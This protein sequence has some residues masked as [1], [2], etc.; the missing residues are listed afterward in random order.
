MTL[1]GEHSIRFFDGNYTQLNV[2]TNGTINFGGASTDY[3][4]SLSEHLSRAQIAVLWDDLNPSGGTN[5]RIRK[6]ETDDRL[7]VTFE[8]LSEYSLT[9]SNTFQAELFYD[10]RIRLSYL[11]IDLS[12]GLVG[13]SPGGVT[14]DSN[15]HVEEDFSALE[16]FWIPTIS[17]DAPDAR[18]NHSAVW[19]GT[20]MII[21]G[22][23]GFVNRG[24]AFPEL[25]TGARYNP[26][27]DRWTPTSL[28]NAA[29]ARGGHTAVW[30]G[31]EMVV[32]GGSN[33]D[34]SMIEGGGRYN[35]VQDA[36][37]PVGTNGEP[38]VR[39]L[40][41]AVWSGEEMIVWGGVDANANPMLTGARFVPASNSW[42]PVT[43]VNA[44]AARCEHSA[45]WTGTK[46]IVWG[47]ND[48]ASQVF[49]SGG[50]FDPG[51]NTWTSTS[52]AG[53]PQDI[54]RGQSAV[55][56]GTEMIV[57][58]GGQS[59]FNPI[60]TGARYNPSTDTW[61]PMSSAGA[62]DA[63]Y[64]HTAVWTGSEM[65]VWGGFGE[66]QNGL[67]SGGRYDPVSD[68]WAPLED[69]GSPDAGYLP[70]GVWAD[71]MFVV[72]GRQRDLDSERQKGGR[73]LPAATTTVAVFSGAERVS[74]GIGTLELTV[75]LGGVLPEEDYTVDFA[76]LEGTATEG[77]DYE[78]ASG[79]LLIPHGQVEGTIL[80]NILDDPTSE[81]FETFSVIL[82][83]PSEGF[84]SSRE[85]TIESSDMEAI[86]SESFEGGSLPQ[87]GWDYG[88]QGTVENA[89]GALRFG[90]QGTAYA[91]VQIDLSR[92]ST[93]VLRFRQRDAPG[94]ETL[95]QLYAGSFTSG[96]G[97]LFSADGV[98]WH[99]LIPYSVN[100]GGVWEEF[101]V[102]LTSAITEAGVD[103]TSQFRLRFQ[104][105]SST[106]SS[107]PDGGIEVD[108]IE[109]LF[110]EAP[111]LQIESI[112]VSET[113][114]T[115]PF[116]VTLSRPS[117][118]PVTVDYV[119]WEV[120][121]VDG[122]DYLGVSN[123]TT[124]TIPANESVGIIPIQIIDDLF[125][126]SEEYF[127]ITLSNPQGALL[128]EGSATASIKIISDERDASGLGPWKRVRG[129]ATYNDI[130]W[131]GSRYVAVG[132]DGAVAVSPDGKAWTRLNLSGNRLEA[133][134]WS[135]E[136]LVAV[137]NGFPAKMLTSRDGIGWREISFPS[138][139]SY[140]LSDIVWSGT[141]F[142]AATRN[143]PSEVFVSTDGE[144]WSTHE[145]D[146]SMQA[147]S[148]TGT[149]FMALRIPVIGGVMTS[150]DG[151]QWSDPVGAVAG[152]DLAYSGSRHVAVGDLYWLN[153]G[154]VPK[155][156]IYFSDNGANWSERVRD[157][158]LLQVVWDGSKYVAVGL[159]GAILTSTDGAN[160]WTSRTSGTTKDLHTVHWN[161]SQFVAG[162]KA[163]LTSPDGI[164][165]TVEQ[166]SEVTSAD[167]QSVTWTGDLLIAVGEEDGQA[168]IETST[169]GVNWNNQ[170]LGTPN[171]LND[172]AHHPGGLVVAVGRGGIIYSS[173]DGV[174]W[175]ARNS[176][177]S[178]NL[179]GVS[180]TGNQF[181][182][183]G[184][185][186]VVVLS[187]DGV[188]WN[189]ETTG[190][191]NPHKLAD[192]VWT[193]TE[194]VAVGT[195]TTNFEQIGIIFTSPDGANWTV[196]NTQLDTTLLGVVWTG[197]QIVVVGN[198][199]AILTST[200]AQ[201]WILRRYSGNEVF[202]DVVWTGS[203]LVTAGS[204]VTSE[205]GVTW[206][207]DGTVTGMNGL[208]WTGNRLIGVGGDD[209]WVK[210]RS[211]LAPE[212]TLSAANRIQVERNESDGPEVSHFRIVGIEGVELRRP[213]GS[214]LS[215]GEF[216]TAAE[217]VQGLSFS[218]LPGENSRFVRAQS[219]FGP[220]EGKTGLA[221]GGINLNPGF[222][223]PTFRLSF[224][225]FIANEGDAVDVDPSPTG[226]DLRY[227]ALIELRL[228]GNAVKGDGPW[229]V[230]MNLSPGTAL[231][232][233]GGRL[234]RLRGEQPG[235]AH[236]HF[237]PVQACG[238][239]RDPGR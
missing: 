121:A 147:I 216:I 95:D 162:G 13:I 86:L 171:S 187:T 178:S 193:G 9:N 110:A 4:E 226:E 85:I 225:R 3:S 188:T 41:T 104:R 205:D 124:L 156:N 123:P 184:A 120:T 170:S 7:V 221:T 131:T 57:W 61:S 80:L 236:R 26:A 224:R 64:W 53:A 152:R 108:D 15:T 174:N 97:V 8:G 58:G 215:E 166:N 102:D 17:E 117:D 63:R 208:A 10:G 76:T 223:L 5:G 149:E 14:Y 209:I 192:V 181:I 118:K 69:T 98:K 96:D 206:V 90:G 219:A 172:V 29:E 229:S 168:V 203:Q 165:W 196:Y 125:E 37:A 142:A 140:N 107:W 227:A 92:A 185:D 94:G 82:R 35:P 232:G 114:G 144:N 54:A 19:T 237:R 231:R 68:S 218:P 81:P 116:A 89:A 122:Q 32:W 186:G 66:N 83:N 163:F 238:S 62:P 130:A 56:T 126:E 65:I 133:I 38:V 234:R 79:T 159:D 42:S 16:V 191:G 151:T 139:V 75:R 47:G 197:Q 220:S 52:L 189:L 136:S 169:D 45:V 106:S 212:L 112:D 33:L 146:W 46:M 194:F 228:D 239:L 73:Y 74:E 160:D 141:Q 20:E 27:E 93:A 67:L 44:P 59:N 119:T 179:A 103:F 134:A 202:E 36:W 157:E 182:A 175:T 132:N 99:T 111:T 199:G 161:G 43:P 176:G 22:G 164:N 115:T 235:S 39:R 155:S 51:T 154:T 77:L 6:F 25:N 100:T 201:S 210:A 200:D 71:E 49:A 173:P 128:P 190:F 28:T 55:W 50:I 91:D 222:E 87:S 60:D 72:W 158:Q 137:Y 198:E 21:W 195:D 217:G 207:V 31:A 23:G 34:G 230:R 138:G 84:V 211:L 78:G 70:T 2:Q 145:V 12:D 101:E 167:L 204:V 105:Q 1:S 129:N 48:F 214:I 143:S 153:G 135:G 177:T 180:W 24:T 88:S 213:D 40:H 18:H 113:V 109:V 127:S 150:L 30:T 183:V 11:G 233:S 148:W